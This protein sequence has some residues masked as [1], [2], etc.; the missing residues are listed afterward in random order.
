VIAVFSRRIVLSTAAL[1]F[2]SGLILMI[3]HAPSVLGQQK[4]PTGSE[5]SV[6]GTTVTLTIGGMSCPACAKG[7]AATLRRASG[8]SSSHVDYDKRQATITYDPA[9]QNAESLKGLVRQSG[10]TCK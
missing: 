10:Y 9:K 8:V 2:A 5:K 1:I 3:Y 7:L 4:A 6:V